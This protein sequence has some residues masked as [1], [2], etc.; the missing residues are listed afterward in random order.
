MTLSLGSRT[1]LLLLLS[2]RVAHGADRLLLN[3]ATEPQLAALEQIDHPEAAAIVALR[4]VRGRLSSVEELRVLGLTDPE[5][6]SIRSRTAVAIQVPDLALGSASFESPE[7]VLEHFSAEPTIREVHQWA[8]DYANLSPRQVERWLAQSVTFATLPQVSLEW[9]LRDDWDQGF[10]YLNLDGAELIPGED[11][12]AVINDA[13]QGQY[14]E[15]KVKLVWDLDKLIMSSERIR[16]INEAQDIVKL[17]DSVLSEVTRLY[18]ER[19]RLQVE[20]LLAPEPD[21]LARV[22]RQLRLMELTA[23][24]DALTGGAF[25]AGLDRS[26]R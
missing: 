17:R 9:K 14:Q 25:S 15:Y 11:P 26:G 8:N 18:F 5:L 20:Q 16:V 21:T 2:S 4:N 3:E 12:V 6:Q 1:A 19:R 13:D 24:I 22:R 23:N 7:A 10:E